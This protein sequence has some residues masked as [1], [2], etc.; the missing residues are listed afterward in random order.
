MSLPTAILNDP[1]R[2]PPAPIE[3]AGEWVAWN[4][5]RTEIVAHGEDLETVYDVAIAA[6]HHNAVFEKVPEAGTYFI[7]GSIRGV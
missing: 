2:P 7:G 4:P 5:A 3:F 6:G 1:N